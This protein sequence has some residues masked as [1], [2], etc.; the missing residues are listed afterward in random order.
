[1]AVISVLVALQAWSE[2]PFGSQWSEYTQKLAI[3]PEDAIEQINVAQ[4]THGGVTVSFAPVRLSECREATEP[5]EEFEVRTSQLFTRVAAFLDRRV[6]TD[7]SELQSR[8]LRMQ[9]YVDLRMNQDQFE[10]NLPIELIKACARCNLGIYMISNDIS[11]YEAA[12]SDR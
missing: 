11:A 8:G 2:G 6:G 3:G 9:L 5:T 12:D 7:F 1:M 4:S 10:S